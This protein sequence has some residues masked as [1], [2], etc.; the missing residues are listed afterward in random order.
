MSEA[1]FKEWQSSRDCLKCH[2]AHLFVFFNAQTDAE[3]HPRIGNFWHIYGWFFFFSWL[4]YLWLSFFLFSCNEF[5]FSCSWFYLDAL[6]SKVICNRSW[7]VWFSKDDRLASA[8]SQKKKKRNVIQIFRNLKSKRL[9]LCKSIAIHFTHEFTGGGMIT[10]NVSRPR[11]QNLSHRVAPVF[12][13][14][15][16]QWV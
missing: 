8:L 5:E 10:V 2:V 7:N 3:I 15:V 12:A 13:R 6:L 14:D 9:L 11:W 1:T 16:H 4:E